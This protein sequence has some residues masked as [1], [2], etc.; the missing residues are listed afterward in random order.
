M[1]S[2]DVSALFL[3]YLVAILHLFC[4]SFSCLSVPR[5]FLRGA[6]RA[7]GLMTVDAPADGKDIGPHAILMDIQGT[8]DHYGDMDFKVAGT[9]SG[10]TAIQARVEPPTLP[11]LAACVR[12]MLTPFSCRL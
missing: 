8:E 11:A 7:V 1:R 5:R 2:T 10:V 3:Q 12:P 9:T 4:T 6:S